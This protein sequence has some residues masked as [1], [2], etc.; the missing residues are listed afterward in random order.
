MERDYGYRHHR[1][2]GHGQYQPA[3]IVLAVLLT[4]ALALVAP[5]TGFVR[6]G[7]HAFVSVHLIFPHH[8]TD[9]GHD[10]EST[11]EP[12]DESRTRWSFT[13]PALTSAGPMVGAGSS[14]TE[15]LLVLVAMSAFIRRDSG[16]GHVGPMRVPPT[17]WDAVPTTPP[18]EVTAL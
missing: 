16:F 1:Q 12:S 14:A 13:A 10:S 11:A 8:H 3:M 9:D 5:A 4:V 2:T 6:G 7:A 15:G 18:R 17:R